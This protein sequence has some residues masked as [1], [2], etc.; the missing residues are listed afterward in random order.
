LHSCAGSNPKKFLKIL[1]IVIPL[2]TSFLIK[3]AIDEFQN[4]TYLT[5]LIHFFQPNFIPKQ[6]IQKTFN[7]FLLFISSLN[8]MEGI[9]LTFFSILFISS[10]HRFLMYM[11]LSLFPTLISLTTL[12]FEIRG[13]GGGGKNIG[14][15]VKVEFF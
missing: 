9:K 5:L 7:I 14:W 6:N 13:M 10:S 1:I 11:S 12:K 3:L 2:L 15:N 4:L 8:G